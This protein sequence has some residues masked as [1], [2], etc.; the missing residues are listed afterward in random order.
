GPIANSLQVTEEANFTNG[1]PVIDGT[2]PNVREALVKGVRA[3]K[4]EARRQGF[5]HLKVG[6]NAVPSF[7]PGNDFWRAIGELG[8]R[9]FVEALDYVGLDF[10]PDVFRPVAPDGQPG[11]LSQMVV[12]ILQAMRESWMPAAGIPASVPIHVAENGWPTSPDRSH[13]RQ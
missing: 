11:D 2:F 6:F 3:A 13:Q 1:P 9:P 7:D 12:V 10:F 4:D 8:Q 5:D